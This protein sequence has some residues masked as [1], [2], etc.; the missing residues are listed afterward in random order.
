MVSVG[1]FSGASYNVCNFLTEMSTF[2]QAIKLTFGKILKTFE[3][4]TDQS[5]VLEKKIK[6]YSKGNFQIHINSRTL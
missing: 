4:F 3:K 2:E 6:K 5:T 1:N